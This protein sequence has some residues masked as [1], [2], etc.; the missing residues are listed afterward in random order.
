[1]P[2]PDLDE[3]IAQLKGARKELRKQMAAKKRQ[4]RAEE[5]R[6]TRLMKKAQGLSAD[7][8]AWLLSKKVAPNAQDVHEQGAQLQ[9]E[10][11]Q[12]QPAQ[13]QHG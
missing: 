2:A 12:G 4:L 3:R 6:R 5:K 8:L 10:D 13:E 9:H 11:H 1:M 7:D